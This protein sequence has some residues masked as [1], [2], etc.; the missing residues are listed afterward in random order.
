MGA[1]Y[2]RELKAYFT[3]MIGYAFIAAVLLF[4]GIYTTAYNLKYMYPMFEYVID[5]STI[6]Y[7]IVVPIL[8]MRVLAEE[9]R[10]K[11]DQL[12]YSL[13][14]RLTDV[15]LGKYLAMV[16]LLAIP[17]AVVSLYPLMLSRYGT[18]S[19]GTAYSAIVGFFLLGCCLIAIGLFMSSVTDSQ[20]VAA[21]ASF[22]ALI[23]CFLMSGITQLLTT[24][25]VASLV[26]L[27]VVSL[28]VGLA[29]RLMTGSLST[30]LLAGLLC[31]VPLVG[32][33]MVRPAVLEGA[34]AQILG[35][36]AAFDQLSNFLNGVFDLT[37]VVYFVSVTVL[38]LFFSVQ[39]V[40]KRRWS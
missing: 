37:A 40:E 13:P 38:F 17:M 19:L 3:G 32:V 35:A 16:T 29:V 25:A 9:R 8:T 6:L 27:T 15:V 5:S 10:Q 24:T 30:A 39:S 28:A 7:V 14:L 34:F 11:T 20:L 33:Y 26:A 2:K 23:L 18:M 22:A 36:L 1:I 21:V 31:E 12:I 4:I